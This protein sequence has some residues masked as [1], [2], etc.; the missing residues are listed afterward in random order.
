ML[1]RVRA[2]NFRTARDVELQLGR[3]GAFI[4]EPGAGKSNM[5][6]AIAALLNPD[7]PLG[8]GDVRR[9]AGSAT[10]EATMTDGTVIGPGYHNGL[11]ALVVAPAELRAGDLLLPG[12]DDTA[13]KATEAIFRNALESAPAPRIA[14]VRGI[15]A[16]AEHVSGAVFLIEEPELFLAPQGH[17]YLYRLFRRLAANGN[18]VLFTT[19]AP[20]LLNVSR[21]EEIHL[22]RRDAGGIT[23]IDN[24][25]PLEA[26]DEFRALCE[27]DAERS[28]LFFSRAA[29]LVE[30]LT[31]KVGLPHAFRALGY[32]I[33]KDAISIINCGGKTNLP[34]F[35]EICKRAHIPYVAV[36]DSDVRGSD[37]PLPELIELNRRLRVAAGRDRYVEFNPDFEGIMGITAR[38]NKPQ[39][40]LAALRSA[41]RRDLPTLVEKVVELTMEAARPTAPTYS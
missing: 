32:D 25:E 15:E 29:V 3:V 40:A 30:G 22:V 16:C 36:F 9:G 19:H 35:I 21:L 6:S 27:F 41:R 14:L 4:G 39:R 26:D 23:T 12:R 1:R 18:Q 20:G 17:R 2:I 7:Q 24:L 8:P 10:L 5:L 34:L 38:N 11:P 13:T 33:D 28:E 31:E 37:K